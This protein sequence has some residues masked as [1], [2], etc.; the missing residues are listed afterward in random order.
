MDAVDFLNGKN[1]MCNYYAAHGGCKACP[2]YDSTWDCD[3]YCF[4][5]PQSAVRIIETFLAKGLI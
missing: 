5:Y 2:I 3:H 4:S 1:K